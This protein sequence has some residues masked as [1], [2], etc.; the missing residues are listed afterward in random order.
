LN[1]KFLYL[2]IDSYFKKFLFITIVKKIPSNLLTIKQ[3][4]KDLERSHIFN[5]KIFKST[6]THQ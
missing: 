2:K 6:F 3:K 1:N 4:I 5:S